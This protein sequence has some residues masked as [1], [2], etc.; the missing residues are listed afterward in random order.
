MYWKNDG[1]NTR[2]NGRRESRWLTRLSELS[3]PQKEGGPAK[4]KKEAKKE[5]RDLNME[6]SFSFPYSDHDKQATS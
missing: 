2:E 4:R 6:N 1:R 3:Y 5:K